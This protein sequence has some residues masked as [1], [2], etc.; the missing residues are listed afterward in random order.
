MCISSSESN[1]TD[2]PVAK[3]AHEQKLL[4][5]F[6]RTHNCEVALKHR[7]VA[8]FNMEHLAT[9]CAFFES[10]NPA[11]SRTKWLAYVG[12][13]SVAPVHSKS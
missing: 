1:P 4:A 6:V 2:T 11:F 12:A 9:L 13:I 7:H 8:P 5:D 3:T 10:V